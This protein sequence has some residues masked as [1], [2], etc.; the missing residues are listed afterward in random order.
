MVRSAPL[1]RVVLLSGPVSAG[2]STLAERL[3]DWRHFTVVKTHDII[4]GLDPKVRLERRAL[5]SAGDFLDRRTRGGWIAQAVGRSVFEGQTEPNV[6]IDAVR[7]PE[8][9]DA[10]RRA[11]G[12]AVLHIHLTAAEPTLMKRYRRKRGDIRELE[13]YGAVRKSRTERTIDRLATIAD[14]VI[15][16]DRCS[17][18]DVLVRAA[19]HMGL[20]GTLFARNVDVLV[21][22]Q[23]GS[24]GKGQV[25]AYLARDYEILVRVGGPNAGHKVWAPPKPHTFHHLPSG[26]EATEGMLVIG[27]GAVL[28]VPDLLTEIF[29]HSVTPERLKIDGRAMLIEDDDVAKEEALRH[30]IGSTGRGVGAATARKV[31]REIAEPPVRLAKDDIDLRPYICDTREIFEE[32]YARGQRVLLEGT[33][34][35]ALS[36]HHGFYPYVTSRDTTV[37]GC[38][39]EAGISPSRVKHVVMVC[40]TYPIRVQSPRGGTSGPM[41]RQLTLKEIARRSGMSLKELRETER[42]STTN[43][44]RRIGEFDWT[45]L[46]MASALNSPTDIALTFA[47]YIDVKNQQARRFDQLTP[48]T[49]NFIEEVERVSSAPV[50]LIATR[51]HERSIIDRR[52]W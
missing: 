37:A 32:S 31:L 29:E 3:K 44:P 2:K 39:A 28:R 13:N 42:T 36:L 20:Y 25:A 30:A 9:V 33:Q 27:P 47:D 46:R 41:R 49:I 23:F 52:I 34:G 14:V 7:I 15:D 51:F 16:T 22:G 11:F 6:V 40:R 38:L 21:G 18:A 35:T 5:Q 19:S 8:Q 4:K 43:R 48:P 26:S 45:L 12:A 17:T 50:S 24:E 10:L 1:Q